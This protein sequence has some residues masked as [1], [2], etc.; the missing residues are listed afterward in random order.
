MTMAAAPGIPTAQG[1]G[2]AVARGLGTRAGH[3]PWRA[4]WESGA[5]RGVRGK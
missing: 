5:R 2:T 3:Q 4:G 1:S